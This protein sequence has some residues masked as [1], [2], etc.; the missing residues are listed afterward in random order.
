M[1]GRMKQQKEK[2]KAVTR[3]M[4]FHNCTVHHFK[5]MNSVASDDTN[6]YNYTFKIT[7]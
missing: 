3:L 6:T 4:S 1:K 7:K 5:V 2:R